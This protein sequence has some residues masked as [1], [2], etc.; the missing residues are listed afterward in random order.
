M[1]ES[2]ALPWDEVK[3][4][5]EVTKPVPYLRPTT[6]E[7]SRK[8]AQRRAVRIFGPRAFAKKNTR[9]G[10]KELGLRKTVPPF[11]VVTLGRGRTWKDATVDAVKNFERGAHY[12]RL[13]GRTL[14]VVPIQVPSSRGL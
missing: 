1:D 4:A 5:L 13:V 3:E 11:Q 12:E 14:L 7:L 6:E 2:A 9:G 10:N 8:E